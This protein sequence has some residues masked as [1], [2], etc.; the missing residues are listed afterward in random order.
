MPISIAKKPR[1]AEKPCTSPRHFHW[2]NQAQTSTA[3]HGTAT[4]AM[5]TIAAGGA[6]NTDFSSVNRKRPNSAAAGAHSTTVAAWGTPA[7]ASAVRHSSL[8]ASPPSQ[9]PVIATRPPPT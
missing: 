5:R 6:S 7:Q 8:P 2:R 4:T 1:Q 9:R 3:I